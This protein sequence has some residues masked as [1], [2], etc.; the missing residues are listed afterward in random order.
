MSRCERC[1]GKASGTLCEQYETEVAL[2]QRIAE[3]EE[4]NKG[5]IG[6]I[7]KLL[8]KNGNLEAELASHAVLYMLGEPCKHPGC[9]QHITHPCEHCGRT[10]GRGVIYIAVP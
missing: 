5:Q 6:I 4:F 7:T 1:D 8:E 2:N 9:L 3:L 10:A